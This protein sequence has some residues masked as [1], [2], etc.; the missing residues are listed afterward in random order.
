MQNIS[1]GTDP[2]QMRVLEIGCGAG[3]VT[4]ALA[5]VFGEI[6]AVDVSGEMIAEARRALA[7]LSN[8]HLYRNNG[9]DLDVL[10]PL[11]FDFPR[12]RSS[13]FSTFRASR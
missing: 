12:T 8:V 10:P 6:H 9:K 13:C 7:D 3:R 11:E 5:K 4:R 2:K 1:Q